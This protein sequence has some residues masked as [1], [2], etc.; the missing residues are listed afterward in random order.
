MSDLTG[1]CACG[2]VR[3]KA[4]GEPRFALICQCRACQL[5]TG[6][7]HAPQFAHP[8]DHFEITGALSDWSRD[9]DADYAV[10]RHFCP[11]CGTPVYGM[12]ARMA[13]TA[14]VLAGT[15][16]DPGAI[17]PSMMVFQ[18][19]RIAWDHQNLGETS[20]ENSRTDPGKGNNT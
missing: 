7:A 6:A 5:M 13:D 9:S 3:Y 14:M 20:D 8:L 2:Q 11:T 17:T 1:G 18:G 4:S 15:L 19:E 12:T 10:R 16:D